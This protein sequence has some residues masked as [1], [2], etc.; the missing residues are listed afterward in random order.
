MDEDGRFMISS[1]GLAALTLGALGQL[2]ERV[3]ALEVGR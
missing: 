3:R 2:W 1:K